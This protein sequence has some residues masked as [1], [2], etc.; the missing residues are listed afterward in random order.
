MAAIIVEKLSEEEINKR[1][2]RQWPSMKKGKSNFLWL[3]DEMEEC[4]IVE[5][6]AKIKTSEGIVEI[7]A[8]D[9][10]TFPEGM[11]CKW[12]II[13]PIEKYYKAY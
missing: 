13:S 1:G 9:F 6:M 3:Y 12:D 2:V 10:V 11:K 8:G 5:G 7:K 4:L